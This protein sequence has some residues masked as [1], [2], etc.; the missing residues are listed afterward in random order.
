MSQNNNN[1][2]TDTEKVE[3]L[4][5][6]IEK[7]KEDKV[8]NENSLKD[9]RL[10]SRPTY[11]AGGIFGAAAIYYNLKKKGK[12]AKFSLLSSALIVFSGHLIDRGEEKFGTI[13]AGGVSA[14]LSGTT[15]ASGFKNKKILPLALGTVAVASMSYHGFFSLYNGLDQVKE[16]IDTHDQNVKI[17]KQ[18]QQQQK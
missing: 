4:K 7:I 16:L 10:S 1:N 15:I 12:L 11:L 5:K 3:R 6:K 18:Q 2:E 17:I 14:I 8:E 13:L 9:L